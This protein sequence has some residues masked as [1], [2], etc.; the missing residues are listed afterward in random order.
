[1]R[2]Q[3]ELTRLTAKIAKA[4]RTITPTT[5]TARLRIIRDMAVCIKLRCEEELSE[6]GVNPTGNGDDDENA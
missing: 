1:M 6:L 2:L 4:I 3:G 5:A